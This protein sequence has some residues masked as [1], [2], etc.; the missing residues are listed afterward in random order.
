MAAEVLP[1]CQRRARAASV[2]LLCLLAAT[3][4]GCSV[5]PVVVRVA[6]GASNTSLVLEDA[7]DMATAA[8]LAAGDAAFAAATLP[9]VTC[10][11]TRLVPTDGSRA[12]VSAALAALESDPTVVAAVVAVPDAGCFASTR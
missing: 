9:G 4:R 3:G 12:S 5:V 7:M 11:R 1:R 2:L 8:A 10:A 6:A